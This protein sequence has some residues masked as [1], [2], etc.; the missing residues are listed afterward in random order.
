M[1]K[2]LIYVLI[3]TTPDRRENLSKCLAALQENKFPHVVCIFENPRIGINKALETMWQGINGLMIILDDDRI[4]APDFLEI[5]YEKFITA[6]PN[7][8]GIAQFCE[9]LNQQRLIGGGLAHT[10]FYKKNWPTCYF[11]NFADTEFTMIIQAW[12]LPYIWVHE[13]KTEHFHPY[14]GKSAIDATYQGAFDNYKKDE[15]LFKDRSSH[16]FYR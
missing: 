11:H 3:P 15:E 12:N 10:D 4:V 7:K 9:E 6:F 14:V 2:D 5:L 1:K 13:A 16:N 8:D